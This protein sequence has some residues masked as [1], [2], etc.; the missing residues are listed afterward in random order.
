MGI[1]RNGMLVYIP[2]MLE[3]FILKLD[4]DARQERTVDIEEFKHFVTYFRLSP[5]EWKKILK[6]LENIGII[7]SHNK[8]KIYFK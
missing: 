5:D 7:E 4:L 6:D 1:S 8:Q 3:Q 2:H